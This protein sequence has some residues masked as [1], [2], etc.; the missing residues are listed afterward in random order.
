MVQSSLS[1]DE[2]VKG[3]TDQWSVTPLWP[4]SGFG[5]GTIFDVD[6]YSVDLLIFKRSGMETGGASA[7]DH[8]MDRGS[9]RA[10]KVEQ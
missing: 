10:H 5:R 2:I 1:P 6:A 4:D 3:N 9:N 8:Y 7:S